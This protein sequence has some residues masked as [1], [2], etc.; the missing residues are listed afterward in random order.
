MVV[1]GQN[2]LCVFLETL[3]E[4]VNKFERCS[5]KKVIVTVIV[6]VE[7]FSREFVASDDSLRSFR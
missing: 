6:I 5:V 4:Q 3:R 2:Y 1:W 7:K